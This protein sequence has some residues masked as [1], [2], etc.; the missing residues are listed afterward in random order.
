MSRNSL[1]GELRYE[2]KTTGR[3]LKCK[4][5]RLYSYGSVTGNGNKWSE[6]VKSPMPAKETTMRLDNKEIFNIQISKFYSCLIVK[7]DPLLSGM[8]I[9]SS[10]D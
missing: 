6:N 8:C 4:Q 9:F 1:G 10:P 2:T 5:G 7:M 3:R